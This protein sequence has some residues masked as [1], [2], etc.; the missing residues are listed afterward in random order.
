M[1]SM[2]LREFKFFAY[3]FYAVKTQVCMRNMKEELCTDHLHSCIFFSSR[4]WQFANK[5]EKVK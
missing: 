5:I 3:W 4:F 1:A 2:K